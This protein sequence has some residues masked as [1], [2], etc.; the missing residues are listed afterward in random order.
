MNDV[1][2]SAGTINEAHHRALGAAERA[3]EYAIECGQLLTEAKQAI[4]HG[5]WKTWVNENCDFAPGTASRYM[6]AAKQK[7]M[8]VD[9]STL[10]ELYGSGNKRRSAPVTNNRDDQ[11]G[12]ATTIQESSDQDIPRG[13]KTVEEATLP[14]KSLSEQERRVREFLRGVELITNATKPGLAYDQQFP[15]EIMLRGDVQEVRDGFAEIGV[16]DIRIPLQGS[17]SFCPSEHQI[18]S[19]QKAYPKLDVEDQLRKCAAWNDANPNKR[20]TNKGIK[21]HIV[22]WL[23]SAENSL[24]QTGA[25]VP[26]NEFENRAVALCEN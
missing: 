2:V 15:Q 24:A 4:P 12:S 19:W 11:G 3:V 25:P 14:S 6:K 23:G 26:S 16:T 10:S 17:K 13:V 22:S 21:K 18:E 8:G 5:L 20:K 1:Q 7:S 9:F